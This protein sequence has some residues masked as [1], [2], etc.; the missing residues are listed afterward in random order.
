MS[1]PKQLQAES[2]ACEQ[3]VAVVLWMLVFMG[4]ASLKAI[5]GCQCTKTKPHCW[6]QNI[7]HICF[8]RRAAILTLES[9]R[10]WLG[11]EKSVWKAKQSKTQQKVSL[12]ISMTNTTSSQLLLFTHSGLT[13]VVHCIAWL[14][15]EAKTMAAQTQKKGY[16]APK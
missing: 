10:N 13:Y 3:S 4:F 11:V 14:L 9:H 16:P 12:G 2:S 8:Q 15:S 5:T 7:S 6:S 1:R